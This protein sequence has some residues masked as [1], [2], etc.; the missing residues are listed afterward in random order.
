MIVKAGRTPRILPFP[1]DHIE[2]TRRRCAA[3]HR[4]RPVARAYAARDASRRGPDTE[5]LVELGGGRLTYRELWDRAAR[6]AGGLR[7]LGIERGDRVGIRLPNGID[8]VLAFFG[9]ELLGAVAVPVNTRFTESEVEYVVDRLGRALRLR[10]RRAAA[11]RR[12]ARRRRPRAQGPGGDLLHERHDRL[13]QGRDDDR[14]RTSSSNTETRRRV[15]RRS[16]RAEGPSWRRS[17]PCRCST[18]PA[19]TAS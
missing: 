7:A 16:T 11:R 19:A 6:V 18:S 3:L 8:W 9:V 12:A 1:M 15:H 2:R 13:P 14:T 5:A 10:A 17:S 4:A